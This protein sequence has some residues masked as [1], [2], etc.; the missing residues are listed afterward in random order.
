MSDAPAPA[1]TAIRLAGLRF[2]FPIDGRTVP[3]LDGIDLEIERRSVVA[4][5][6]PNGCGK[7]TLLRVIAG[8]LA[9][10]GRWGR[11]RGTPRRGA[12]PPGRA[13]LPGAAPASVAD[14]ANQRRLSAR[15]RRPRTGGTRGTR[16]GAPGARRPSRL[17][18]GPGRASCPEGCASGWRSRGRW[19]SSRPSSCSTSRSARSMRS[20]ANGSM[21][22]SSALGADRLDDRPG[23]PQHPGGGLPRRS[24]HRDVAAAGRRRGRHRRGPAP[25][26]AAARP[27][28]GGRHPHRGRD[29]RA[30]SAAP[31][32]TR[33]RWRRE[34]SGRHDEPDEVIAVS[35][36][37]GR[38]ILP[39]VAFVGFLVDLAGDRLDR[40]LPDVHPAGPGPWSPS[41]SSRRGSRASSGTTS[42]RRWV[43]S[44]S[45]SRSGPPPRCRPAISSPAPGWRTA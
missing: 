30:S 39:I 27:R 1:P 28:R 13:R 12:G 42:S 18:R 17:G 5:V 33:S 38:V 20:P 9:R 22:S 35:D 26:A 44:S 40:Q 43:R 36:T 4:L 32:T 24:R 3:V 41:A 10:R 2:S 14:R 16:A 19:P 21:S 7:S 11:G 23:D 34:P 6:G 37:R 15:G 29:P 25:A 31:P 8:L 45:A